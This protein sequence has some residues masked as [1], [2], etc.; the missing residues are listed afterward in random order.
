MSGHEPGP[1]GYGCPVCLQTTDDIGFYSRECDGG[2]LHV[3]WNDDDPYPVDNEPVNGNEP[4]Y[5]TDTLYYE[6]RR[7]DA[8]FTE[9]AKVQDGKIVEA[10]EMRTRYQ[11]RIDFEITGRRVD[12]NEIVRALGEIGNLT[13]L[14]EGI[15]TATIFRQEAL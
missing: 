5:Y 9:P 6:C 12:S 8:E 3:W 15:E 10:G 2:Q 13:G 1:D 11:Y 7:C 14:I 4:G